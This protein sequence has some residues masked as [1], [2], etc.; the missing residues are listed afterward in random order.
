MEQT[1]NV[2]RLL[3]YNIC[4]PHDNPC[5]RAYFNHMVRLY[6]QKSMDQL[7]L[8]GEVR[9]YNRLYEGISEEN[10]LLDWIT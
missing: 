3:L 5:F 10:R 8:E 4:S 7:R 9:R 1:I 6:E 2:D